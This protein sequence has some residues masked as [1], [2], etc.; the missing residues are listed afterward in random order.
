MSGIALYRYAQIESARRAEERRQAEIA[1]L[2]RQGHDRQRSGALYRCILVVLQ[3]SEADKALLDHV[4]ALAARV[5]ARLNLLRVISVADDGGGLGRQWQLE[6]GSSGWRR[7]LEAEGYLPRLARRLEQAGLDVETAIVI[8][9]RSEADEI[10]AYAA[11]HGCDLIAMPSDARPWYARWLGHSQAGAVQRKATV[12][13]L[14]VGS[15]TCLPPAKRVAPKANRWMEL[16]GE[17]HL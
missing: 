4:Q 13:T 6:T 2:L 5:Q 11:E 10:V 12:P 9:T 3:G 16:L 15:A 1:R 17:P 14:S 7:K 8:G